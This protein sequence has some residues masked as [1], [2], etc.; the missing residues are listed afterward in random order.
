MYVNDYNAQLLHQ[1][2]LRD[3][4]N[5]RA[6]SEL[7]RDASEPVPNEIQAGLLYSIRNWIQTRIQQQEVTDVRR[8][9]AV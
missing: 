9:H 2:R 3:A 5:L 7:I 4:A 1:D 8:A 6:Q